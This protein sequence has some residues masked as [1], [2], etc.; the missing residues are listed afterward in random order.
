MSRRKQTSTK[1]TSK[2]PKLSQ[3]P[4]TPVQ[5]ATRWLLTPYRR[6]Q[7]LRRRRPHHSFKRTRRRDYHR[8]LD[9]P[10]YFAFTHQVNR[11]LFT[12]KK[13]FITATL[14]FGGLVLI[15]GG[16][17]STETYNQIAES[18]NDDA[19]EVGGVVKA[20][21]LAATIIASGP[22]GEVQ[23]V[24]VALAIIIV[25][26]TTVWLL[27][28]I[29]A[30]NKP[31]FRD[32]LYSAGSPIMATVAVGLIIMVQ[33][34]PAGLLALV[35]GALAQTSYIAEGLGAFLF[36]T[37]AALVIVLTLYWLTST[38]F[39]LIIITLPGMYPWRA[40]RAASDIVLGRRLRILLR[41]LW[42]GIGALIIWTVVL[43]AAVYVDQWLRSQFEW[44]VN[45]PLVPALIVF[46][47]IITTIWVST[48]VYMMY[49]MAVA[50]DAK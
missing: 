19:I 21:L 10:G 7:Q 22:S 35:Y 34:I 42:L 26:L 31:R 6:L 23:Q 40:V 17:S 30:G 38:F 43:I 27:R 50:D 8:T 25:W 12:H 3:K 4:L 37:T 45:I 20:G 49:R 48:Y 41:L 39:A 33:L 36:F 1:A 18:I 28:E 14:V 32:G 24:Y 5:K 13:L 29:F 11:T 9:L 2:K 15:L 47:S 46:L 44:V 16:L